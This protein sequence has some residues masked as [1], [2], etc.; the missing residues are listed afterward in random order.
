M[1]NTKIIII[2]IIILAITFLGAYYSQKKNNI[3]NTTKNEIKDTVTP[4]ETNEFY[5]SLGG[6]GNIEFTKSASRLLDSFS[7]EKLAEN[8]LGCSMDQN[9][10]YF[11]NL[12]NKFDKSDML[13]T[14]SFKYKNIPNG[15]WVISTMPNK[16]GYKNL[17][18]FN[19]D[20]G[21][22]EAGG[23]MYP[24]LVSEKYLLFTNSCGSGVDSPESRI[25]SELETILK[26]SVKLK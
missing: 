9:K 1:K 2:I 22:C 12:L 11:D 7:S 4:E 17:E 21:I 18:D 23:T 6:R 25:C 8:A 20:F 14:Y 15:E 26:E 3:P 24:M 10:E 5:Y 13:Y 16:L 19:K